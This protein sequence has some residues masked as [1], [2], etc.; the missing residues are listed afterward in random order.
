[1][2]V[3]IGRII[4]LCTFPSVL[5]FSR[6]LSRELN[7]H[8]PDLIPTISTSLTLGCGGEELNLLLRN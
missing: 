1:M 8:L 4:I 2:L 5:S 3:N 6:A 7:S